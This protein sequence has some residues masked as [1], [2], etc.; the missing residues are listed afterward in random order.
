MK[1][2]LEVRASYN[3]PDFEEHDAPE[4]EIRVLRDELSKLVGPDF[5]MALVFERNGKREVLR[6]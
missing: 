1:V 4:L 5:S 6:G 2:E 3:V